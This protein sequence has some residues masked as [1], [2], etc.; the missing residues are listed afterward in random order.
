MADTEN[1][2]NST[3]NQSNNN[4][5]SSSSSSNS[6]NNSSSSTNH[7]NSDTRDSNRDEAQQSSGRGSGF[8]YPCLLGQINDEQRNEIA[9]WKMQRQLPDQNDLPEHVTLLHT[10]SGARCYLIGTAHVSK[11]SV[12]VVETVCHSTLRLHQVAL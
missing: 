8:E 7:G 2:P 9:L 11:T 10:P 1:N 5:N 6:S 4:N 12:Q 3:E